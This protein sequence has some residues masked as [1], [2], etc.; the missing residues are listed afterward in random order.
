MWLSKTSKPTR[1]NALSRLVIVKA[2]IERAKQNLL[3]MEAALNQSYGYRIGANKHKKTA[4][5]GIPARVA[6]VLPDV[7]VIV[8]V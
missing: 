6:V 8:T 1:L 4:F 7:P 3:D 2:K 5:V